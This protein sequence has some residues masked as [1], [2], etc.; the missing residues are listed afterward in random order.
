MSPVFHS[1]VF[2]FGSQQ[3]VKF[4]KKALELLGDSAGPEFLASTQPQEESVRVTVG[5]PYSYSL[6]DMDWRDGPITSASLTGT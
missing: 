5:L 3:E 1:N 4:T 2:C 6:R